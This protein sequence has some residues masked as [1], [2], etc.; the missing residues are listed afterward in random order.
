MGQVF[1]QL[2]QNRDTNGTLNFVSTDNVARDMLA[3]IEAFGEEKLQYYGGS[4]GTVLGAVFSTMF[5]DRVGRVVLDGCLDMDSYFR[6]DLKNQMVDSDKAMQAFFDSCHS[7]GPETCAFYASS[8]AE[9][10]ANLETVYDTVRT[11]PVPVFSGDTFGVITYD[12][13][14]MVVV[15]ALQQPANTFPQLAAGLAE[16]S[17][18]NGTIIYQLFAQAFSENLDITESMIAI[19]CSDADPLNDNA[20][21]LENYMSGINSTFAGT[22]ALPVMTQCSG[23][24]VHPESRFKGPVGANT[25]FPL[26]V[27]GNTAD[28]ITPLSAA[29]KTSSSFP[30]SVVLQQDSVGHTSLSSQ[31]SCTFQHL[32]AYFNNGTLPAEGTICPVDISLFPIGNGT[33]SSQSKRSLFRR[34]Y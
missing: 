17:T 15:G 6:N 4:Y 2:A 32:A 28:P 18:G 1:G 25:S 13:L 8:P 12:A 11:Q 3:M 29:K 16:L 26:L 27:I 24:M 21:Q 7:A 33:D 23:W 9:I 19:E 20:S 14:R 34:R 10:E 31:S 30:G 5:P 22:V